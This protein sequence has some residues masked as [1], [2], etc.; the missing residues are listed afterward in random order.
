MGNA[1]FEMGNGLVAMFAG[2]WRPWEGTRG[3][4]KAPVVGQ[5]L[6]FAFATCEPNEV[7]APIHQKA[8]P[9]ILSTDDECEAWLTAPAAELP[10]LQRPLPAAQMRRA[11][12]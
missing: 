6:L 12:G 2:I 5:H 11:Q 7:V 4:K 10:K 8:M 9:V 3:P 1:W